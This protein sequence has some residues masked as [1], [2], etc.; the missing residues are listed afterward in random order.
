MSMN[1]VNFIHILL[2]GPTMIY[3]GALSK[4]QLSNKKNISID[5]LFGAITVYALFIPFIVRHKFIK[6]KIKDWSRRNWINFFH[7]VVF[8]F[9][10]LYIGLVGRNISKFFQYIAVAI[11]ISQISIHLYL[12]FDKNHKH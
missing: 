5:L 3:A 2:L 8:F 9:I 11:G 12:L 6:E 7:Y 4:S 10:F 1:Q